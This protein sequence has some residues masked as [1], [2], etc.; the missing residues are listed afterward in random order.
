MTTGAWAIPGGPGPARSGGIF[1]NQDVVIPQY[2]Q[3]LTH[4]F[5]WRNNKY[6]SS[7]PIQGWDGSGSLLIIPSITAWMGAFVNEGITFVIEQIQVMSDRRIELKIPYDYVAE[8]QTITF[9]IFNL[10]PQRDSGYGMSF[11]NSSD[12]FNIT[13]TGTIG[14]ARWAWEGTI[15][16]ALNIPSYPNSYVFGQCD[17]GS[18]GMSRSGNTIYLYRNVNDSAGGSNHDGAN[19]YCRIV[20]FGTNPNGVPEHNGGFN[21][22]SSDGQ[23]CIFST[24]NS[25][26]TV[27]GLIG[28]G[29]GNTGIPKPMGLLLPSY[30]AIYGSSGSDTAQHNRSLI[31]NG[32]TITT[33]FGS[34]MYRGNLPAPQNIYVNYTLPYLNAA[35]YFASAQ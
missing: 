19:A 5:Q 9:Q 12:V 6:A 14:Q 27:Q 13:D 20:V 1:F 33:G 28:S 11:Y 25:P 31:T 35:N 21:I 18:I 17:N 24:A 15:N 7:P 23:R 16:Q 4:T 2:I 26:F 8:S 34:R 10:R 32:S 3:T 30:G 22:Y 29:G